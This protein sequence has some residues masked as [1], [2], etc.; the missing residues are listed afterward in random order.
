M[1]VNS[2]FG[3]RAA[4]TSKCHGQM[5]R[6]A[7]EGSRGEAE[8]VFVARSSGSYEG[9]ALKVRRRILESVWEWTRCQQRCLEQGS[10]SVLLGPLAFVSILILQFA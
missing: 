6:W 2:K 10:R 8:G 4:E 1:G 9:A 5:G 3:G 7:E